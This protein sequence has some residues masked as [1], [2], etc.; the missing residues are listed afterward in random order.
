MKGTF[1]GVT[2]YC[3]PGSEVL[4]NFGYRWVD[5]ESGQVQIPVSAAVI[6]CIYPSNNCCHLLERYEIWKSF[7]IYTKQL[8]LKK[9]Q[10]YWLTIKRNAK[11]P[12]LNTSTNTHRKELM[13]TSA[14][15][16]ATFEWDN[17]FVIA[18]LIF[19]SLIFCYVNQ[20]SCVKA[21]TQIYLLTI[22][23]WKFL[24]AYP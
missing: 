2:K 21:T 3:W 12:S 23:P 24:L 6:N 17:A 10:V 9:M 7:V 20:L 11:A 16:S 5:R 19:C 22:G 1:H 4:R 18:A 14:Y 13:H 8:Q 15:W